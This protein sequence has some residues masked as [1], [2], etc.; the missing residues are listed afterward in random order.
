M[1]YGRESAQASWTE[2]RNAPVLHPRQSATSGLAAGGLT[3]GGLTATSGGAATLGEATTQLL[4]QTTALR[5]AATSGLAAGG[6]TASG[7][8]SSGLAA[9]GLTASGCTA[10]LGHARTQLLEQTAQRLAA[11]SGRT[12]SGFTSSGLA[13]SGLTTRGLTGSGRTTTRLAKQASLGAGGCHDNDNGQ[14]R[15]KDTTLH[16]RRSPCKEEPGGKSLF[17][18]FLNHPQAELGSEPRY[19]YRRAAG[20]LLA[21]Q[22]IFATTRILQFRL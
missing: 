19:L 14:H 21:K 22:P 2:P 8:T 3:A 16:G 18:Q 17:G 20:R 1:S 4:E 13:A 6:L 11:P 5:S 7:L 15:E 12:A 10:A 9:G